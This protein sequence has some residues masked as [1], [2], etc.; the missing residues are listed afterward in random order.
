MLKLLLIGHR[1][2]GKTS[3]LNS[4]VFEDSIVKVSLDQYIEENTGTTIGDI[5]K[6]RGEDFFRK[7]E[8]NCLNQIIEET[9]GQSVVVDL[10]AG[11]EGEKPHNFKA[12]WVQRSID[13]SQSQFLNRPNLDG[14]LKISQ[15]RF[16]ER[17]E[18]FKEMADFELEVPEGE[19]GKPH[20]VK[21]LLGALFS[22]YK[23]E[24]RNSR[25]FL[26]LLNDQQAQHCPV[27]SQIGGLGFELRDDL[28]SNQLMTFL[29][30]WNATSIISFRDPKRRDQTEKLVVDQKLWDWPL[31]WGWNND[32]P[33]LSLHERQDSLIETIKA[34]PETEQI[35]KL[36]VPVKNFEELQLGYEWAKEQPKSRSFLP[37]SDD[38]RFAWYRLVTADAMAYSFVRMGQGSAPDQPS[39]VEVL[40]YSPFRSHFAAILGDPVKHSLTPSFHRGYFNNRHMNCLHVPVK[41][42]ELAESLPL[43]KK[44]GLKCAAVTSPLKEEAGRLIDKGPMNSL[45]IDDSQ[46]MATNTD[47][48]GFKALCK[49]AEGK[50]VAVWGGGG[51]IQAIRAFLPDATFFSSRTGEKKAGPELESADVIIW[52][53]GRQHFESLGVFPPEGWNPEL[54]IDLNYG[55]DSPGIECAHNFGCQYQ[56]GLVMFENQAVKQQEFWNECGLK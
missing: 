12:L 49:G 27:L 26:T 11:F 47:G 34:I 23:F 6:N 1:G 20:E 9:E 35:I 42:G 48:Y 13:S 38:G 37:I 53:V 24:L 4:G 45:F 25:W 56:S 54:V 7:L 40:R 52:A 31:E 5:F 16:K 33:I 10:G 8:I 18:R 29:K 41:K 28:L 14:S 17:E 32:A 44:L 36:A 15:E 30:Q 3:F 39:L 55:Q 22:Q 2:V 21:A 43:L 19:Y 46:I 50:K 51:T